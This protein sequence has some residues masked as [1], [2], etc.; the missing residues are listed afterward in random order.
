MAKCTE[1]T[2]S[3]KPC[4]A[5][6]GPSGKCA[7]HAAG[8][9]RAK[10]LAQKSVE[11]REAARQKAQ[12][13]FSATAKAPQSPEELIEEL[14]I[15]FRDVKAGALDQ[16]LGKALAT[17]GNSLLRAF[18]VIDVKKQLTEIEKLLRERS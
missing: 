8:K 14:G 1:K 15:V 4:R 7:M 17:V 9:G 10:E 2:K 6:A 5:K 11:S 16:N 3:G 13:L 12:E 18:E